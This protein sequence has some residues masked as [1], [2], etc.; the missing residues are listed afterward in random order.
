M[1]LP[2]LRLAD[3]LDGYDRLMITPET[4]NKV[5]IVLDWV[6]VLVVVGWFFVQLVT[7]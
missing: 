7:L 5:W 4:A 2:G 3:T 6:A 1:R